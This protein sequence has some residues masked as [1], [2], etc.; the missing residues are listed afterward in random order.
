MS[1]V[2]AWI[3]ETETPIRA[4]IRFNGTPSSPRSRRASEYS[5]T[6]LGATN[7]CSSS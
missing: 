4:A 1:L 2:Q 6:F 7:R 5:A 3:V